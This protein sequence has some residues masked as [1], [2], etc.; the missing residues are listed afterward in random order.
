MEGAASLHNAVVDVCKVQQL[1]D[2]T[3][4]SVCSL[5]TRRLLLKCTAGCRA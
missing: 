1:I 3:V 2:G 4:H 5:G